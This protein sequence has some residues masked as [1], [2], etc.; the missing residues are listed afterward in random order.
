MGK[1]D[2][3]IDEIKQ[4]NKNLRFEQLAKALIRIGY[5]QSQPRGG[6]SHYKFLKSGKPTIVIPKIT[7]SIAVYLEMVR[8]AVL[9]HE[10]ETANR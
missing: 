9:E 6:S 8:E 3:L 10:V 2:K 4:R 5:T 1:F 7:P